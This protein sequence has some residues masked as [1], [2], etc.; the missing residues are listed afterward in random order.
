MPW[1]NISDDQVKIV[2]QVNSSLTVQGF[3][4]KTFKSWK[5]F[6]TKLFHMQ[7]VTDRLGKIAII[8]NCFAS[9]TR[10]SLLAMDLETQAE[11]KDYKFIEL[12]H[13]LTIYHYSPNQNKLAL[14]QLYSGVSQTSGDSV[15]MFLEKI[16]KL[17]EG[18]FGPVNRWTSNQALLIV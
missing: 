9:S 3:S 5:V 12:L 2:A 13:T 14:R 15:K 17:E 1:M 10:S 6:F 4:T 18:A 11:N 16:C 7:F 8:Y